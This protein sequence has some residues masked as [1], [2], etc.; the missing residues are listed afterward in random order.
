MTAL[1]G[2]FPGRSEDAIRSKALEMTLHDAW[3]RLRGDGGDWADEKTKVLMEAIRGILDTIPLVR[4]TMRDKEVLRQ[5]AFRRDLQD[6]W[7]SKRV[8][9]VRDTTFR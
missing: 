6:H 2:Y 8:L 9:M 1:F 7:R 3:E 5:L 4:G